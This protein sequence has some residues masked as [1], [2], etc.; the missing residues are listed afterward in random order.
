[1][2]YER[3]FDCVF[4]CLPEMWK[5]MELRERTGKSVNN[6]FE[7][8]CRNQSS[9]K[10]K[11]HYVSRSVRKGSWFHMS[12]MDMCTVL[13]VMRKWFGRCPQKYAVTR[14]GCW[15]TA[16]DVPPEHEIIPQDAQPGTSSS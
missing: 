4:I 3:R 13:L 6:G 1:M 14:L 7:W 8:M 2:V 10:E 9:V 15:F 12:N 16:Q 5:P 11:N